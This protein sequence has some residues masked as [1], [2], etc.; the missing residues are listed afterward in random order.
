MSKRE[1]KTQYIY[2]GYMLYTLIAGEGLL[3]KNQYCADV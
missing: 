3:K 2:K 1:L